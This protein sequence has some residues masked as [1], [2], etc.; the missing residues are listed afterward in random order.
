MSDGAGTHLVMT[1]SSSIHLVGFAFVTLV[2]AGLGALACGQVASIGSD[3]SG[4]SA[5]SP[6]DEPGDSSLDPEP[7]PDDAAAP[8]IPEDASLPTQGVLACPSSDGGSSLSY[9]RSCNGPSD[10]SIGYVS[11]DCCGSLSAYGINVA[12]QS[13][14]DESAKTCGVAA[15]CDCAPKLARSEDG[16]TSLYADHHDIQVGCLDRRCI[17]YIVK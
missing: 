10:C 15:V 11:V 8:P 6:N 2:T 12:E 3:K 5:L 13:R 4:D 1:R 14:F 16:E 9:D 17:T 7:T